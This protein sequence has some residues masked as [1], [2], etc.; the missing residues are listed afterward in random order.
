METFRRLSAL[1]SWNLDQCGFR[2]P[3]MS[4]IEYML[5]KAGILM[6]LAFLW[7]LFCGLTGRSMQTG[8][9]YNQVAPTARSKEAE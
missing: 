3:L 6:V 9:P 7:G 2:L 4:Y 8:Q 1:E 5:W